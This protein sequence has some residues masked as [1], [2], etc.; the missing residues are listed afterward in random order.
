MNCT[1]YEMREGIKVAKKNYVG[2]CGSCVDCDLSDS[3]TFLYETTFKCTRYNRSVK[4]DEPAC[5]RFEPAKNR[6]NELIE[7]YDR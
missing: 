2:C 1:Q 4:A 6:T 3:Y 7:K 5:D